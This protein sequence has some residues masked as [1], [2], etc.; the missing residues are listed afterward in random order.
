MSWTRRNLLESGLKAGVAAAAGAVRA[1]TAGQHSEPHRFFGVHPFIGAHPGAVF[2][3]RTS[4]VHKMDSEA[5]LAEGLKLA[6][7][8]FVPLDRPG[9][10]VSHRIILKPNVCSRRS[11]TRP[12]EELWGTIY[13]CPNCLHHQEV[14]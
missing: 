8:I 10:P 12:P 3:R 9:V 7:E 11:E 2:I 13:K 6:R 1:A 5:K 4:V 14:C